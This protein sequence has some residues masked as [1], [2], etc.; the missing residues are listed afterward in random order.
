MSRN[1]YMIFFVLGLFIA[2]AAGCGSGGSSGV[3]AAAAPNAAA[4]ASAP[5]IDCHNTYDRR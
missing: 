2:M 4:V 1:I 3:T 5:C